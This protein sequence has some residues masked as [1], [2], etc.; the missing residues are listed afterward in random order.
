[1]HTTIASIP[2]SIHPIVNGLREILTRFNPTVRYLHLYPIVQHYVECYIYGSTYEIYCIDPLTEFCI[3]FML[4]TEHRKYV[5]SQIRCS[6][7][8]LLHPIHCMAEDHQLEILGISWD[9]DYLGIVDLTSRQREIVPL[10]YLSSVV[11]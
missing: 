9:S 11:R 2:I 3:D 10:P 8:L 4:P 6:I 1:M 5:E 7:Q